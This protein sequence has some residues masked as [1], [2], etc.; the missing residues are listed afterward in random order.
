MIAFET[1]IRIT[2]QRRMNEEVIR[3]L[4]EIDDEEII[5]DVENR[6]EL[7]KATN[8]CK[9]I[10]NKSINRKNT[11]NNVESVRNINV[12]ENQPSVAGSEEKEE[13]EE[14]AVV[15]VERLNTKNDKTADTAKPDT[16]LEKEIHYFFTLCNNLTLVFCF[17][18]SGKRLNK[19]N[20]IYQKLQ[21][22]AIQYTDVLHIARKISEIE[23]LKYI[24]FSK[25]QLAYFN[26]VCKL[27]N[28]LKK[29]RPSKL[30]EF[31]KYSLDTHQQHK[32]IAEYLKKVAST[33]KKKRIDRK[34]IGIWD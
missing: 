9:T 26:H 16:L 30:T 19:L 2:Y 8:I 13:K 15:T 23:K 22:Y 33:E 27:E 24:M 7:K 25:K 34:L 5:K 4:F 21:E 1:I 11:D 31:Y 29:G 20:E 17:V 3:V 32:D 6:L 14:K 18:C 12:D 10:K 28:P